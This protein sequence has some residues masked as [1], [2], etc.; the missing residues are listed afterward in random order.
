MAII[1]GTGGNDSTTGSSD[2]D[3]FY[4]LAGADYVH[5]Y[6]SIDTLYGGEGDDSLIGGIEGDF[7]SGDGGNDWLHGSADN[8]SFFGGSGIDTIYY[9]QYTDGITV[10]LAAG[11][12]TSAGGQGF[13]RVDADIEAII[14][15][16]VADTMWGSSRDD[17]FFGDAG[18]DLLVGRGGNDTLFGDE[19]AITTG[20]VD[21]I[22]GGAGTD[23]IYG[24]DAG[25][26]IHFGADNTIGAGGA[27]Y[28][29]YYVSRSDGSNTI[30]DSS[31]SNELVLF[32]QFGTTSLFAAG[33]GVHDTSAL[34]SPLSVGYVLGANGTSGGVNLSIVSGTATLSFASDGGNVVFNTSQ[35]QTITLWDHDLT[36]G[37]TQEVYNWN[38]TTYAFAYYI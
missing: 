26:L 12:I 9:A 32:G 18:D 30:V 29:Y 38:G 36:S 31:G 1:T 17:I 10:D 37:H 25:D 15:S 4:G 11:T 35:I 20:G 19:N 16:T 23:T 13:D 6:E 14:G 2:S 24:G 21:T 27:G 34:A 33:T 22:Y 28:D 3:T 5:A 8:D 7:Y